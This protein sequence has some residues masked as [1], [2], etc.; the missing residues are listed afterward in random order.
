MKCVTQSSNIPGGSKWK[1]LNQLYCSR[2]PK[3][4][5]LDHRILTVLPLPTPARTDHGWHQLARAHM[6]TEAGLRALGSPGGCGLALRQD[7]ATWMA[8]GLVRIST[9]DVGAGVRLLELIRQFAG[10]PDKLVGDGS[11]PN[12]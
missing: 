3:L 6:A 5:L 2:G 7:R 4:R 11:D 9:P 8:S 1:T 10:N 12:L